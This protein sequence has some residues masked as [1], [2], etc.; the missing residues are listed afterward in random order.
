MEQQATGVLYRRSEQVDE[1]RVG[2]RV[3]LYHRE[4]GNGVVLNPSGSMVWDELRSPRS[5]DDIIN[6]LA[7]RHPSVEKER[8]TRDVVG[9]VDSLREQ[10]LL[11]ASE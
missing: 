3:V 10:N 1:T 6:T 5:V 8:V 7:A 4:S 11:T 2:D 9:Y